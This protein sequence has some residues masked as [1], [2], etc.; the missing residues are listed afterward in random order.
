MSSSTTTA[1][2]W[3]PASIATL[4][5]SMPP[6]WKS[7][8]LFEL[9]PPP[10]RA[11]LTLVHHSFHLPLLLSSAGIRR[12]PRSRLPG[13]APPS[14]DPAVSLALPYLPNRDNLQFR[15]HNCPF[16]QMLSCWCSGRFR[17]PAH[18]A[19]SPSLRLPP[20]PRKA[21]ILIRFITLYQQQVFRCHRGY[22]PDDAPPSMHGIF[23]P[24]NFAPLSP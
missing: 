4:K 5:P 21:T 18:C 7:W 23:P 13:K 14:V 11:E 8:D 3:F 2:L 19:K 20:R 6:L 1:A 9:S 15:A 12:V 10:Q 22:R 17:F 24:E 16:V